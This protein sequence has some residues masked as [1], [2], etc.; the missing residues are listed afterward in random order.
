VRSKDEI[1]DELRAGLTALSQ[2]G[3]NLPGIAVH[4]NKDALIEKMVESIRRVDYVAV[5]KGRD[6]SPDRG[7]PTSVHFDPI[8]AAIRH[9][10]NGDIDE[11]CWLI[12]LSIHFGQALNT[13]W[14]LIR[15]VY[16][17]LGQAQVWSWKRASFNP[18]ALS[19]W[20]AANYV[21]LKSDG[22]RFGNHRKYES[23]NPAKRYWTGSV[24]ESYIAWVMEHGSHDALFN[25]AWAQ[26]GGD[27]R[28]AF[29]LLYNSMRSVKRFGR[30]GKF[31]Y[32]T[33]VSKVGISEIIAD[34]AYLNEATGP[35]R[36]AKLLFGGRTNA[37]QSAIAL[38]K[39]LKILDNTL[40]VGMQVLEDSL[41]NWQKSP[42]RFKRYRG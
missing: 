28:G 1:R 7:D 24:I 35:L 2:A 38:E 12:F 18:E 14:L 29:R 37:P 41:C 34:S 5:L 10:N 13:G 9:Y 32:L 31:D 4:E 40:Q 8:R 25:D 23:I 33:M 36:G 15:D 27:P 42:G 17:A 26:S 6:I 20:I 39:E 11:A 3:V 21:T 16:G 22:R 30:T 19:D